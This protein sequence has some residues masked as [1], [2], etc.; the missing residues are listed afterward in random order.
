MLDPIY[1]GIRIID[2]SVAPRRR[3]DSRNS[4]RE[5]RP[6]DSEWRRRADSVDGKTARGLWRG[7]G[8]LARAVGPPFVARVAPDSGGWV[9]SGLSH[10]RPPAGA[11]APVE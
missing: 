6:A 2:D 11:A 4:V 7:A 9:R 8:S 3:D 10:N 1:R 5:R